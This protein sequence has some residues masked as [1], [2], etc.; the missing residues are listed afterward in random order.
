M[1]P[2]AAAD[3]IRQN[4]YSAVTRCTLHEDTGDRQGWIVS[5]HASHGS[6]VFDDAGVIA[7]AEKSKLVQNA[8]HYSDCAVNRAPALEPGECDCGGL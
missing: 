4:C 2:E 5:G 8:A 6:N 3:Y 1:T 7:F